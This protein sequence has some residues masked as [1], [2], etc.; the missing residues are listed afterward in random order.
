MIEVVAATK[1]SAD[2]FWNRSPLG[3]SLKRLEADRRLTS[4]IAFENRSGLPEIYNDSIDVATSAEIV[5]FIHDDVWI[6]DIFFIDRILDGLQAF[7]LLGVAGNRRRVARQPSWAFQNDSFVWDEPKYLS[8]RIGY[9][10]TSFSNIAWFGESPAACELLDGAFLA[11]R[12]TVLRQHQVAFDRRFAFHFYDLDFC[13]TARHKKLR[14]GTWPICLTH[15]SSGA[16][17][18][19]DW[20]AA[21]DVYLEKWGD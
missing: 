6:D 2:E 3:A 15:Q 20:K 7:H 13:R 17:G 14:V 8:G 12:K 10:S 18:T 16:Y 9:G 1:F 5:V 21:Y 19:P 11:A 4:R